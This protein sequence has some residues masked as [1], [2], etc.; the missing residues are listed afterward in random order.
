M[1][2]GTG[3][4]PIAVGI[5]RAVIRNGAR[6][7]F[8]NVVDPVDKLEAGARPGRA[9]RLAEHLMRLNFPPRGNDPPGHVLIRIDPGRTGLSPLCPVRRAARSAG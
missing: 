1:A 3:K 5:A 4:T 9:G 8:F 2:H 6:G 7:R